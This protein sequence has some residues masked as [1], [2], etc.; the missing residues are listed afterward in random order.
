MNP[1]HEDRILEASLEEVL[2]GHYPPDLSA[3]IVQVWE[4][5]HA[6]QSAAEMPS[7]VPQFSPLAATA[8]EEPV[9]PPVGPVEVAERRPRVRRRRQP[10]SPWL[11]ACLAGGLLALLVVVGVHVARTASRMIATAPPEPSGWVEF[12]PPG[13]DSAGQRVSPRIEHE[14]SPPSGED[15]REAPPA[16]SPPGLAEHLPDTLAE[17]EL[18]LSTEQE[19][20]V[21]PPTSPPVRRATPRTDREVVAMI[22]R[23]V[24]ETWREHG[25]A[26]A[27]AA[28]EAT[29]CR[30]VYRRLIGRR[31]TAE[32]LEQFLGDPSEDRRATLVA[33]LLDGEEHAAHWARTWTRVL[34][35]PA[36]SSMAGT[37]QETALRHY[38]VGAFAEDKPY[39]EL[40]AELIAASGTYHPRAEDYEGASGFLTLFP[41]GDHQAVTDGVA[42]VFWGQQLSCVRCHDHPANERKQSDY[43]ELNAFFRQLQW[44]PHP[45]ELGMQLVDEDFS[46]ETGVVED[47][48]VFYR[49]L[50]GRLRIAYPRVAGLTVSRSGRVAD[51]HRRR[52]LASR[53]SR[54]SAFPVAGVN[55]VWAELL[56]YGLV[57]PVD[58]MGS[59]NRPLNEELLQELGEQ[60]AAH[61]FQMKSLIRWVVLSSPFGLSDQ[62]TAESWMDTPE[63]GGRPLFARFYPEPPRTSPDLYANLMRAVDARPPHLDTT[64]GRFARR[65]WLRGETVL[66]PIIDTAGP[67]AL[68]GP[69]WLDQ[70]AE[71]H[72][73]ADQKIEHL[74]LS[75]LG[76]KPVGR[77]AMAARLLLADRLDER[78]AVREL[79]QTLWTSRLGTATRP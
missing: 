66:P 73:E 78:L 15:D 71:S 61:D 38:L 27:P 46:G 4:Q 43:W 34:K 12:P 60:W 50:S 23:L 55:R 75:L 62:P 39:D 9:A 72:L 41:P 48:E 44:R 30:R 52:E 54:A 14:A 67:E 10:E 65:T 21:A 1:D 28:D 57:E 22:D 70:L 16:D 74:F 20:A 69:K 58:D 49:D 18:G 56:G 11:G 19:L 45:E 35:G 79:W 32:E 26:P 3:K 2:G 6:I 37:R 13:I 17:L 31:P 42:R 47:A 25:I 8:G 68:P 29:W 51:V 24:Q 33:R 63:T 7:P 40:A 36:G 53:I 76:R 77:E 5:R 59:H 64:A